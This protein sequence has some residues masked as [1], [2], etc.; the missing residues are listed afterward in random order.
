MSET[1][2]SAPGPQSARFVTKSGRRKRARPVANRTRATATSPT[3]ANTSC[4]AA[5]RSIAAVPMR[6]ASP[7]V[8]A[9]CRGRRA[10]RD[11]TRQSEDALRAVGQARD[12]E[13]GADT[14]RERFHLPDEDDE[15]AVPAAQAFGVE[16]HPPDGSGRRHAPRGRPQAAAARSWSRGRR[17]PAPMRRCRRRAAQGRAYPR[18]RPALAAAEAAGT[19]VS[20]IAPRRYSGSAFNTYISTSTPGGSPSGP[21]HFL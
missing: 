6:P 14:C 7:R 19:D 16:T 2:G 9:G 11:R 10:R 13:L 4:S 12:I 3:N 8:G 21:N 1:I 17:A 18:S 15:G 20:V 5:A